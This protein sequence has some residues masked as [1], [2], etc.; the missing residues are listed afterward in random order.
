MHAKT[1]YLLMQPVQASQPGFLCL[2]M[3]W[4]RHVV[5]QSCHSHFI[6]SILPIISGKPC[7]CS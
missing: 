7:L 2:L 4:P 1:K 5:E 6:Q 3:C